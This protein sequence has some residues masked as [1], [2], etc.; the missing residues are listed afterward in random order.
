MKRKYSWFAMAAV[1]ASTAAAGCGDNSRQCG[2]N[3]HDVNGVCVGDGAPI[4]CTDGTRL[5]DSMDGCVIDPNSC[6][7]GTVLV[8]SQ[9]VDPGHVTADVNEAVEPNGFG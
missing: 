2:T 7:D 6:Q 8:G 4:M 5:N 1:L 9:C 3:T